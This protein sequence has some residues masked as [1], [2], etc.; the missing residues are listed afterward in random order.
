[1]AALVALGAD[2]NLRDKLRATPLMWAC[3]GGHLPAVDVLLTAGAHIDFKN[4]AQQTAKML[5]E[6]GGHAEVGGCSGRAAAL[7]RVFWSHGID[8]GSACD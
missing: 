2:V 7:S 8:D 6:A 4:T 5:A 1:M 3:A